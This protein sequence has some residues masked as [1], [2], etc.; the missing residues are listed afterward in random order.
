[1][2][3]KH[4]KLTTTQELTEQLSL[5]SIPGG[6]PGA[7]GE[8]DGRRREGSPEEFPSLV[9]GDGFYF[10]LVNGVVGLGRGGG[11]G[12]VWSLEFA[13]SRTFG[14]W[15]SANPP[16]SRLTGQCR[17]VGRLQLG[18]FAYWALKQFRVLDKYPKKMGSE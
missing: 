8:G 14:L 12:A 6:S 17:A 18:Q 16:E 7:H 3:N 2:L 11:E 13:F 10:G 5:P 9:V 1:M 15:R 4:D